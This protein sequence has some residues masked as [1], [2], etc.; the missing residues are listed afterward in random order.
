[1]SLLFNQ[2]CLNEGLLP[3]YTCF[4]MHDPAA[5]DYTDTQKYWCSLVKD[6]L[7]TIKKK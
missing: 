7:P 4:K 5:H 3:K 1:M 6:K 2:A